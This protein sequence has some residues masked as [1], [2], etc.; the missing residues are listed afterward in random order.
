MQLEVKVDASLQKLIHKYQ[1]LPEDVDMAVLKGVVRV[2]EEFRKEVV[3][4]QGLSKYPRHPEGTPTPSPAGD[5]PAQV[6]GRLFRSVKAGPPVR[7][8]QAHYKVSIGPQKVPYARAQELGNPKQNLP[9]RP[10]MAPARERLLR[11]SSTIYFNEVRR[12]LTG[13]KG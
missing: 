2:V 1:S 7:V 10:Y 9:A 8:K 11:R 13:K 12:V 6:T 4:R 5:P 3:G